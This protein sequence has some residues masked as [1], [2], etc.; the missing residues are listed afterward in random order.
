MESVSQIAPELSAGS[1]AALTRSAAP[2]SVVEIT[3]FD[4]MLAGMV[5]YYPHQEI[6]SE[7]MEQFRWELRRLAEIHG[8]PALREAMLSLRRRPHQKFF[9]HPN[10]VQGEL[11]A[12]ATRAKQKAEKSLPPLGCV[13]CRES[14]AIGLVPIERN[15]ERCVEMCECRKAREAARKEIANTWG[16]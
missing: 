3:Q 14:V 7:T 12:M 8:L 13:V 11:E 2:L 15:G 1:T 16:C 6:P 9:P 10:D 5:A 4:Q